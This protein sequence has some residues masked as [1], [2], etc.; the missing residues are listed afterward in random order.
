MKNLTMEEYAKRC[1]AWRIT[2]TDAN[3]IFKA[4]NEHLGKSKEEFLNIGEPAEMLFYLLSAYTDLESKYE[5]LKHDFEGLK[6]RT[7]GTTAGQK[8]HEM[9]HKDSKSIVRVMSIRQDDAAF[10]ELVSKLV[11]R[12]SLT[13]GEKRLLYEIFNE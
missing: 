3:L 8:P 13:E 6:S 11:H 7:C 9:P 1:N 2:Y 12:N 5:N 10:E 4:L